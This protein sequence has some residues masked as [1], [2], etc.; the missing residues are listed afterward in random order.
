LVTAIICNEAFEILGDESNLQKYP[1]LGTTGK[2][3]SPQ[4]Q[5]LV[6]MIFLF[7]RWDM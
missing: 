3:I 2:K 7:P 5:A 4:K 1:E 6:K